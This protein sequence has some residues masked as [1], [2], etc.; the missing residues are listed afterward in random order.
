[1][2]FHLALAALLLNIFPLHVCAADLPVSVQ[3]CDAVVHDFVFQ[4]NFTN[5]SAKELTSV[6]FAV[7]T[8]S[9]VLVMNPFKGSVAPGASARARLRANIAFEMQWFQAELRC[10]PTAVTYADGTAWHNPDVPSDMAG[11]LVQTPGS[12]IAMTECWALDGGGHTRFSEVHVSYVDTAAQP[13]THVD[14]GLTENGVL[15]WHKVDV[16]MFSPNV[17][18][19]HVFEQRNGGIIGSDMMHQRCVVLGV[20]YADGSTWTNPSPPVA[21]SWPPIDATAKAAGGGLNVTGCIVRKP[22]SG[23]PILAGRDWDVTYVND[24]ALKVIAVAFALVSNGS[25]VGAGQQVE[26]VDPGSQHGN[27]FFAP[28]TDDVP[29]PMCVPIRVD[30]ADGTEWLNPSIPAPSN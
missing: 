25:I 22:R 24:G 23:I 14:I 19:L 26:N 27:R 30:Y 11:A 2:R 20:T 29:D 16:G 5:A 17:P 8:A 18:I 1:V 15:V 12:P 4:T 13:A 10:V 6:N 3:S 21:A 28:T 7:M 9:G